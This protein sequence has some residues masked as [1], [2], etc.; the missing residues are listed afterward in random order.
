MIR[1]A[2]RSP[3][4]IASK[5]AASL[6]IGAA[7]FT[8][9]GLHAEDEPQLDAEL[10]DERDLLQAPAEESE[11]PATNQQPLGPEGNKRGGTGYGG[12]CPEPC[13]LPAF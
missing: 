2:S 8:S 7:L 12:E 4:N 9:R 13:K 1:P 11:T 6:L 3:S 5:L 10:L